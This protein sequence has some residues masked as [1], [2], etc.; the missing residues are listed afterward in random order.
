[1][2]SNTKE[3]NIVTGDESQ[4][5]GNHEPTS[6]CDPNDSTFFID[7]YNDGST[8]NT[9]AIYDVKGHLIG[10]IVDADGDGI[11]EQMLLDAEDIV[12]AQIARQ[13]LEDIR[14]GKTKLVSGAE[15]DARLS[16]ILDG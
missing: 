11:T 9:Y 16:A 3:A 14:T 2:A 15:L 7:K 13:C 4:P 1:M 6:Q 12:D 10:T 8:D 5:N